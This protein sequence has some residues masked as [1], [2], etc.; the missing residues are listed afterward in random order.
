MGEKRFQRDHHKGRF[1]VLEHTSHIGL[2]YVTTLLLPFQSMTVRVYKRFAEGFDSIFVVHDYAN[3][4]ASIL[5]FSSECST[6]TPI[7]AY[8][9]N[10]FFPINE[11]LPSTKVYFKSQPVRGLIVLKCSA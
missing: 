11:K 3:E 5:D 8:P 4:E 1:K 7:L 9:P 2:T 6:V 10:K